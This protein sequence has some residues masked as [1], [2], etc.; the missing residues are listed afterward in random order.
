MIH[1]RKPLTFSGYSLITVPIINADSLNK[2]NNKQ[3]PLKFHKH[4]YDSYSNA[5]QTQQR[6]CESCR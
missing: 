2:N 6:V 1:I 3:H 4:T 5:G